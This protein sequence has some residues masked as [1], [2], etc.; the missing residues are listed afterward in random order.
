MQLLNS[1][2]RTRTREHSWTYVTRSEYLEYS[3]VQK[4]SACSHIKTIISTFRC[5]W[6]FLLFFRLFFKSTL[7]LGCVKMW[8][9]SS[10][11]HS[12][13]FPFVIKQIYISFWLSGKLYGLEFIPT[14]FRKVYNMMSKQRVPFEICSF[15]ELCCNWSHPQRFCSVTR[16]NVNGN[17]G[18]SWSLNLCYFCMFF[19]YTK[20]L[21]TVVKLL[22]GAIFLFALGLETQ[23]LRWPAAPKLLLV[24]QVAFFSKLIYF[25]WNLN[26][27]TW[28]VLDTMLMP[29]TMH[30]CLLWGQKKVRGLFTI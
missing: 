14:H 12:S 15:K 19:K 18:F 9:I 2:A 30:T 24:L 29:A 13:C 23:D 21:K 27:R 25:D 16:G 8:N 28:I 11:W 20:Y 22:L 26:G 17:V 10:S 6:F 7:M 1:L 3:H 5:A 4:S